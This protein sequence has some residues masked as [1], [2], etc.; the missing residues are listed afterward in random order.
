[1]SVDPITCVVGLGNPGP[2]YEDTRHNVGFWLVD[3][4]A[5]RYGAVM[6]AENKFAGEVARIRTPVGECW[7]LKPMTYMNHSGR[8]VSAL[9]KFY[10][11]SLSKM[12]VA[13]DELDMAPGVIRLKKGG[14]HGGHNGLRD[15]VS[16]MGGKDFHRVRIGIGHPG[17]RDG[18]SDYVLSRPYKT[19]QEL[20]ERG[21]DELERHWE[22]VQAGD[23]GKAMQEI[24]TAT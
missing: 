8:A 13:H 4:L 14:G 7:L 11:L 21:L 1:M 9:A 23:M 19:E 5:R 16:A 12:L 18:V 24:H 10:K 15:I 17:H 2:K 20:I 22:T 3:R 6:R